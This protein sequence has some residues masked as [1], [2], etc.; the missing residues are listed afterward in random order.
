MESNPNYINQDDFNKILHAIP[1]LGIR[2]WNN[3][4]IV[5]L[6]KILYHMAL[7]PSEGIK[8]K[9][10]DFDLKNRFMFLGKTKTSTNDKAVIPKVFLE[11]LS[12][13]LASKPEG[14]LFPNLSYGTFWVWLGKL[15]ILLNIEA[16]Q[17]GNRE[18]MKENTKGH[19]FRKSWGKDAL[20]SLGFEKINVISAH[21]RHKK[22]SM[23]FDHYLKG[24]IQTV[25]DTI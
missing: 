23:T 3:D 14:R 22:P 6:M 10:E 9:K 1:Q 21:L 17:A 8:A 7:R 18:N 19:I 16:W 20:E 5:M 2:K 24:N 13:Y 11:E 12:E 4:D 15:G 25:K